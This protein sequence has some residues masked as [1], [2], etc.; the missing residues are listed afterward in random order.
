MYRVLSLLIA[1]AISI[2]GCATVAPVSDS[3]TCAKSGMLLA[4]K[5]FSEGNATVWTGK[6]TAIGS[7]SGIS[8]SCRVPENEA[9]KCEV[10]RIA[11]IA[12]PKFEYNENIG[13]KR[14]LTGVGYVLWIIPGVVLKLVYDSQYDKALSASNEISKTS[15]SCSALTKN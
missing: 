6:T 15:A 12:Q 8:L 4:G 13:T 5:S 9:D 11:S 1:T 3:E 10:N 2:S 7:S 14:T